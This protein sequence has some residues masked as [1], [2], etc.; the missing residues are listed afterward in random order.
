MFGL[1]V[2]FSWFGTI[3]WGAGIQVAL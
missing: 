1:F 3:A 2:E